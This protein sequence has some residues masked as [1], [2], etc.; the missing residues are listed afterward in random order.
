MAWYDQLITDIKGVVAGMATDVKGILPRLL[1]SGGTAGQVLAKT[2]ASDYAVGWTTVA[3]GGGGDT[4]VVLTTATV[5]EN[6]SANKTIFSFEG[7]ANARYTINA[8]LT[9]AGDSANLGVLLGMSLPTGANSTLTFYGPQ[10]NSGAL[11]QGT[12]NGS[13]NFAGTAAWQNGGVKA[14]LNVTASVVMGS[15]AGTVALQ[16]RKAGSGTFTISQPSSMSY[17]AA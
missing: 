4:V 8:V 5:T 16:F 2:S 13:G 14:T 12:A 10:A 6:A 15:T 9:G 3:P 17:R 1:P 11:V 7:V